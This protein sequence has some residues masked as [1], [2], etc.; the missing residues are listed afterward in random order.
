MLKAVSPMIF[1]LR[2]STLILTLVGSAYLSGCATLPAGE[3]DLLGA[4]IEQAIGERPSFDS[5]GSKEISDRVAAL[6]AEPITPE[7]AARIAIANNPRV[8]MAYAVLG[9]ARGDFLDG[10]LE[11]IE[12][13]DGEGLFKNDRE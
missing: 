12:V 1:R 11:S 2:R 10:V 13:F 3:Q 9:V 7:T 5:R 4:R 8:Q 6:L